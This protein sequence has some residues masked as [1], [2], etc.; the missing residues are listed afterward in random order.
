MADAPDIALP[1]PDDGFAVPALVPLA[2]EPALADE[3][4]QAKQPENQSRRRRDRE[5]RQVSSSLA[6]AFP[7]DL[8]ALPEREQILARF[9]ALS[10]L[11]NLRA[12]KGNV[13][14]IAA[15]ARS[16]RA[17]LGQLLQIYGYYDADVIQTV[18]G[19]APGESAAAAV[20]S[21]RFDIVP[22]ARFRFGAVD[23]GDIAATGADEAAL[24]QQFGIKT[25]DPLYTQ[26]IVDG[27]ARLDKALGDSGYAFASVGEPDLLVDHERDEGDLTVPVAPG[28]KYRFGAVNSDDPGY[29]SGR[30]L[31]EIARFRRGQIYQRSQVDDL[32]QAILATG[33]A[34]SVTVTPREAAPPQGGEPGTVALDVALKRA[35][36]RTIAGA[37]GYDSIDGFRLEAS[38]EHRNLFPPEGM[39]RL[40]GIA[41]TKEQLA[42]ITFRRNNFKGRDQVLTVDLY[43]DTVDRDAYAARTVAFSTT[44]EKLS[45]LIFQ[46]PF[47]WSAGVLLEVTDE[48]EAIVANAVG[49]STT[50]E[51]AALPLT[52]KWD[53]SDSL[54]DPTRGWRLGLSASPEYSHSNAASGQYVRL[55]LDAS[56]YQPLAKG[57]VLAARTRIGSIS[58]V[59]LDTIAPSRRFYAGGGGSVRGFG[60]EEIGPR[61][62]LG[63]PSGGRSLTEFS[64]EAR[65]DTGLFGGAM[66]VVPFLDA[67]AVDEETTPRLHDPRFGAGVG[68][69]YKTGF[70]PLRVDV[71]TP[72]G[73]R[74]GESLIAVYV[75]LGQAF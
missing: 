49:P 33:L 40:R 29:L 52:A 37:I 34:S 51:I 14:Q 12:D 70:G 7:A 2:P 26:A 68:I 58:G 30:H 28:G 73:R 10:A 45:T 25:G 43:A 27:R 59:P 38:W 56:A 65:I 24:R 4:K 19:I 31:A 32:R 53:A 48:R 44:F 3:L 66:Q 22:G 36:Q 60:Y 57:V 62:A 5:T 18:S 47:T 63:Q 71:G 72:L 74:P 42:G 6:L 64:L 13:A 17:L 35:P 50:Y 39:L 67:G 15:R 16:D 1:W 21:V 8:Q 46:K 9:R 61:D 69:R 20:P 55:Q 41:G 75:A 11:E 54:L 23:L